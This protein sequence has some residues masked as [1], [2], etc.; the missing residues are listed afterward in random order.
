MP[1]REPKTKEPAEPESLSTSLLKL[2]RDIVSSPQKT[3]QFKAT[4]RALFWFVFP[5]I[6]V[7]LLAVGACACVVAEIVVHGG[8]AATMAAMIATASTAGP[9]G[10][11]TRSAARAA[12]ER[13]RARR[14]AAAESAT[15]AV[16]SDD[17]S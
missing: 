8:V 2:G 5:I 15:R 11:A 17:R 13:R 9:A 6:T 14:D 12:R 1:S 16:G 4:L 3:K 10:K 7:T